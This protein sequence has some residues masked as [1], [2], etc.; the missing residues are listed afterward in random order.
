MKK[1]MIQKVNILRQKKVG[2]NGV[3]KSHITTET[4]F[5]CNG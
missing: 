2:E 1:D 3:S 5:K 4:Y